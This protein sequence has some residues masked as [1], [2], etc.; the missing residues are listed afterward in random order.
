MNKKIKPKE[1]T[2]NKEQFNLDTY[3]NDIDKLNNNKNIND[4]SSNIFEFINKMPFANLN[5]YYDIKTSLFLKHIEELNL[6][7][8]WASESILTHDEIKYPYNKLFLILFKQISLYINEISRLNIQINQKNKIEKNFEL[9]LAE[10]KQKEKENIMNK[11]MIRNLQRDNRLLQINNNKNKLEMEK[12]YKKLKMQKNINCMGQY[13]TTNTSSIRHS[14]KNISSWSPRMSNSSI[15][16]E[17]GVLNTQGPISK[18]YNDLIYKKKKKKNDSI[19]I[20]SSF[21]SKNKLNKAV[22]QGLTQCDDEIKNLELIEKLLFKIKNTF[23]HKG[24]KTC[25]MNNKDKLYKNKIYKKL[26]IPNKKI[27]HRANK[28]DYIKKFK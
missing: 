9:K 10:M 27:Y 14:G 16:N 4:N 8:F 19:D 1:N 12:L 6:K 2:D 26:L 25:Y 22:N 11:Q 5:D 24:D 23:M 28:S 20:G 15:E 3:S 13:T 18:K 7:F 21:Q 17:L